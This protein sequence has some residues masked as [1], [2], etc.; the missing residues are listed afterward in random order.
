[1]VFTGIQEDDREDTEYI[2]QAFLHRKFKLDYEVQYERVHRVGKYKKFSEHSR[3]IVAKFISKTVNLFAPTPQTN[4]RETRFCV[5]IQ[6]PPK[7]EQKRKKLYPVM[8]QAK[9]EKKRTKPVRNFLYIY[10][11]M[12]TP[13]PE[14]TPKLRRAQGQNPT[15]T[16]TIKRQTNP[17]KRQQQGSSDNTRSLIR[18][19]GGSNRFQFANFIIERLWC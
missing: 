17:F 7:I 1:M 16:P 10:G 11:E 5:N 9:K 3:N 13:P 8:G 4:L 6:F 2:L 15:G 18:V 14:P 12:Y 19:R